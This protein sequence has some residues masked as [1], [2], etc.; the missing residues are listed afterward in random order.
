MFFSVANKFGAFCGTIT[1]IV[2]MAWLSVGAIITNP[3]AQRLNVSV[4]G[5]YNESIYSINSNFS[6]N[7]ILSFNE[8]QSSLK[9]I[10]KCYALSYMWYTTCGAL[11]TISS[12]LVVSVLT[13]GFRNQVD[14]SL[15]V[16]DL[17]AC[18]NRAPQSASMVVDTEF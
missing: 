3:Q 13:G 11:V 10:E 14:R 4:A 1:G 7:P 12:G 15:L 5:C 9:G 16:F 2:T 8:T 6:I 18:F 17:T